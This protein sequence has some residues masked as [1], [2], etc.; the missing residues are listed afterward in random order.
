METPNGSQ[1]EQY[2]VASS[3]TNLHE[4]GSIAS[5]DKGKPLA[6]GTGDTGGGQPTEGVVAPGGQPK[7]E[8]SRSTHKLGS[9]SGTSLDQKVGGEWKDDGENKECVEQ[10]VSIFLQTATYLLD[11]H[12]LKVGWVLIRCS[13]VHSWHC[14][15]L[16]CVWDMN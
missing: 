1:Q 12:A 2:K 15:L 3:S 13:E 16:R 8:G 10:P 5:E 4:T 9:L 7:G 14:S 11:V 6:A